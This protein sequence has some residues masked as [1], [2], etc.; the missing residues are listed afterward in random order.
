MN[1]ALAALRILDMTNRKGSF[2]TAAEALEQV[3]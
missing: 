3:Q 2:A 1:L